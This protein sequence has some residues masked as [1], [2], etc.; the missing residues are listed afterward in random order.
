MV[1]V[2]LSPVASENIGNGRGC[3]L[4]DSRPRRATPPSGAPLERIQFR[5]KLNAL[6][7]FLSGRI[8]G[9]KTGSHFS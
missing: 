8:F 2:L 5:W 6:Q 7:S 9:R 4:L 1:M 3:H